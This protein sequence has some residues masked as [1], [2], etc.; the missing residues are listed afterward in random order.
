[1]LEKLFSMQLTAL[2]FAQSGDFKKKKKVWVQI[3]P[4]FHD[5]LM[6]GSVNCV[7][8]KHMKRR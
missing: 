5:H 8:L 6:N 2:C 1:M 7:N 4:F 3:V